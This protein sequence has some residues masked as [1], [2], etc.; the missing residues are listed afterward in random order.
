M[1]LAH[2]GMMK[3]IKVT[4]NLRGATLAEIFFFFF[5]NESSSVKV[6]FPEKM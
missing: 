5:E 3:Q 6:S 1:I 4:S 2:F